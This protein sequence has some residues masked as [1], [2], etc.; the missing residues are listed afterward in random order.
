M[1]P[2][3]NIFNN[4]I[5]Q[6]VEISESELLA[7]NVRCE[8]VHFAKGQLIIKAGERQENLYFITKGIVKNFIETETGGS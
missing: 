6:H 2:H 8:K 7:F 5:K 4:F 1:D 3:F